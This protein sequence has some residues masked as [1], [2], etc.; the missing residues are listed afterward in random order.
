M[1]PSITPWG[2]VIWGMSIMENQEPCIVSL[3]AREERRRSK[4]FG[5]SYCYHTE[6]TSYEEDQAL[7]AMRMCRV[8]ASYC[9]PPKTE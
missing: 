4:V 7:Q 2:A 6:A 8:M 5:D 9:P 3:L 1:V